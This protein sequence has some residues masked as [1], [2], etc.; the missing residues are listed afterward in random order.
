MRRPHSWAPL[1]MAAGLALVGGSRGLGAART[2]APTAAA[3]EA[4]IT[5]MTANLLGHSQFAHH[6]L[7]DELAGKFLARYLDDLDG[8]RSLFLRSD[9]QEFAAYRSALARNTLVLGDTRAAHA[10]FARYLQRLAQQ[11]AYTTKLLRTTQLDFSGHD[12]YSYDREHRER[13]AD[14]KSAQALWRQQLRAEYLQAKL[15]DKQPDEIVHV[16]TRRRTQQLA[17]MKALDDSEVLEIY[18]NALA[19]VYDPHSDYLG[20]EAMENLDIAMNLSL[21]GIGASLA[22]EDGYCMI[23]ELIPG[24][25]AA[26]SGLLEPGDR[27]LAVAQGQGEPVDITELPLT[28]AVELIRGPKGSTVKLT[29]L[30]VG[31]ADGAPTKTVTLVRDRIN[32]EDQRAKASII[33]LPA[34]AGGPLRVG[35]IDLPSFYAARG[36][37]GPEAGHGATADVAT[38]LGKLKA[39]QVRGIVLDLRGNGGGSLDEA[40]SL[41]GLFIR[42]GPVVQTRNLAGDIEV[43]ADQDPTVAYA[44]PLVVL[45]SRFTAS[46]SEILTGALQDYGR[47]VVVGDTATFGKGTVQSI[48][49]LASVMA[50]AGEV[51]AYDP[52][53]LKNPLPWD[54][55]PLVPHDHLNLVAPYLGVLSERSS[56]R[57]RSDRRFVHL[58]GEMARLKQSTA[59]KSVSLN[60]AER[61]QELAQVKREEEEGAREER[62][63]PAPRPT[64]YA[65]TLRN[66]A[67]PGLPPPAVPK[68]SAKPEGADKPS[69]EAT[70]HDRAAGGDPILDEA[71]RILADYV[72][73]LGRRRPSPNL[74]R[75]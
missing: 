71:T 1:L 45:T 68:P 67:R 40:V 3:T 70:G 58:A 60:E 26:H 11:V 42:Q 75:L 27:I 32:L 72:D 20:H 64:T 44:G 6:P 2:D 23:R 17:T 28:R 33:D 50:A 30:P 15:S 16:L 12:V 21:F 19:H 48:L 4:D 56:G 73:L 65:I 13:P 59:E 39:E 43:N 66:A 34:T 36:G 10:I 14:L 63:Q 61:R 5:R 53:A 69:W 47:A 8:T 62:Q 74:S 31:A 22:Y 25:P 52:G 46:A 37:T 18:L 54:A 29:I 49:P 41:T 55:V 24:G 57:V 35:V 38:L 7:D 51:Y 9:V